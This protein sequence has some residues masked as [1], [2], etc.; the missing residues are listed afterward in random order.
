M[1]RWV[2]LVVLVVAL[3]AGATVLVPYLMSD[4][5]DDSEVKPPFPVAKASD[6]PPPEAT[7]EEDLT[8]NF[9]VMSQQSEGQHEWVVKNTGK[10]ELSLSQGPSTCSCTI[11]SLKKDE[12]LS[13]KTGE[14]TV[15]KLTWQTRDNNGHFDKSAS[16]LTNDPKRPKIDFHV[17]G[18]VAPPLVMFPAL[19]ALNFN[20]V[21]NDSSPAIQFAVFA[22]DKPDLKILSTKT[23]RPDLFSVRYQPLTDAER[24]DI[25]MAMT[26]SANLAQKKVGS[27]KSMPKDIPG[28]HIEVELHPGPALGN[29]REELV[30]LTDHPKRA[31]M[32]LPIVGKITGPISSTP[33]RIRMTDVISRK[34]AENEVFLWV[35]GQEITKFEVE[36]TPN[37]LKVDIAPVD[38][39]T[40]PGAKTGKGTRYRLTVHVPPGT[41]PGSIND[42]II[43]KTD[44]PRASV[45]KI[46]VNVPILGAG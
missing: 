29:F 8:Q 27:E 35:K 39:K 21:E 4:P 37:K 16:I 46:P 31:E 3:S 36:K 1:M 5:K 38:E 41:P 18:S 42:E 40:E 33:E 20:T 15:V 44:H 13:L 6:G 12:G 19:S 25:Q 23:S 24:T 26:Q 11:T 22:P 14:T 2:L 9:G 43:L 32:R 45:V 30:I 17:E 28:Y 7:I 10:G 34:G